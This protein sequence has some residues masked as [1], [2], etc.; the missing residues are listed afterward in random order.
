MNLR[1]S[2]DPQSSRLRRAVAGS[3]LIGALLIA[4]ALAAAPAFASELAPIVSSEAASDVHSDAAMLHA[5]I[6]PNGTTTKYHFEYGTSECSLGSCEKTPAIDV[7]I[8]SS[9]SPR[10]VSVQLSG[11]TPGTTYHWRV[12]A[13]NIA[14]EVTFGAGRT[15]TTYPYEAVHVDNC[16]NA[17]V[18]QQTSAALLPDCRA[19]ELA[20]AANTGGYDVESDLSAGQT[21]YPGYPDASGATGTSR[22][23]YGI[24]DGAIPGVAGEPTNNG[25]DPYVATRGSE[26]WNTEY[27]GVP[28]GDPF[29]D[30]KSVV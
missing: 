16:P 17:H 28:A 18:R 13:R 9:P 11:L 15:F 24:D 26:G 22:L 3:A 2:L 25:I 8:G 30:R 23:L 19:Y 29:A 27:V 12:E 6:N 14:Q 10:L 4:A 20:S 7:N 1:R 5:V 21:P